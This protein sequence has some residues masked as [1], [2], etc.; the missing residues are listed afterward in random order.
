MQP[1]LKRVL[2]APPQALCKN[3]RDLEVIDVSNCVSLT[4][5]AIRAISFYCRGLT[6]L[7]MSGCAEVAGHP[8][9]R[10]L[11]ESTS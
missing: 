6:T 9:R 5:R 7:R 4:Q 10:S 2:L 8:A 11:C 1:V 3:T